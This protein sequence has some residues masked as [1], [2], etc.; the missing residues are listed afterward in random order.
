VVTGSAFPLYDRNPGS[1]V[2]PEAAESRD[3][4]QNQQQILHDRDH[5]S[6]LAL[7]LEPDTATRVEGPPT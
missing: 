7:P 5:P 6:S 3:W 4:I 2:S 1:E